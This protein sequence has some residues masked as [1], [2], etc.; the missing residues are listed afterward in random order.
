[1]GYIERSG[2]QKMCRF[3]KNIEKVWNVFAETSKYMRGGSG[4]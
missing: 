1:M 3:G 4:N 2:C